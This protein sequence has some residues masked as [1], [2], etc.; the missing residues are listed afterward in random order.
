MALKYLN[1]SNLFLS[2]SSPRKD[3][4]SI[5]VSNVARTKYSQING[6]PHEAALIL[7]SFIAA[8]QS[9]EAKG[10]VLQGAMYGPD[11][12]SIFIYTEDEDWD[13]HIVCQVD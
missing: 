12:A 13:R 9:I 10:Y 7:P 4:P 6:G 3:P 11:G 2:T 8:L 5:F 1:L